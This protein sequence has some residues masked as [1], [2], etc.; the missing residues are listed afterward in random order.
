[1]AR[2]AFRKWGSRIDSSWWE[3]GYSMGHW[4]SFQRPWGSG[5]AGVT[6][7]NLFQPLA[8]VPPSVPTEPV[9]TFRNWRHRA[10]IQ[11]PSLPADEALQVCDAKAPRP[12]PMM[13]ATVRM[14]SSSIPHIR[15]AAAGV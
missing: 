1:M 6:G 10:T 15:A 12:S 3:S 13:S 11:P 14:R 5:W 8:L 7:M 2:P 4:S 9:S